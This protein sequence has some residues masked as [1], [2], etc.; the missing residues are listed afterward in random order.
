MTTNLATPPAAPPT[1]PAVRPIRVGFVL[2]AMQ[3]AGAEVL[4]TQTIRHL[5]G[6]IEPVVLCLDAVGPL[7]RR[8][9]A[10]GVPV[11]SLNR[12]PGR[13]WGV[14]RRLAGAVRAFDLELLHA[15]QYSPFFYAA[16]AKLLTWPRPKLVLTEHG[17]HFPDVVS[18]RRRL[19]NRWLLAGRADAVNA[20]C[21]FSARALR[22]LDGFTARPVEVIPNGVELE[23]YDAPA[24]RAALRARLGLAEGTVYVAHV[25]RHHPVK[26]QATLLHAF[27]EAARNR[28][29]AELLMAG[30]GPL[31]GKLEALAAT[32]KVAGRV[33]FLGVRR[34]VPDLLRAADVFTLPSVSEAASLTLLEAMASG[35]PAVVTDVGGNPELVRHER[36]GLLVPRGDAAA[37]AAALGRLID[38]TDE[39]RR[40]GE[41]GRR[42]ARARFRLGDTL[43]AYGR[44]Y[45]RL[46]RGRGE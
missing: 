33:Q 25:A 1:T 16:L 41:A 35:L 39:R 9:L 42:R 28:P 7:G 40:L 17:R 10:E 34:D 12:R 2:H 3:V 45:E 5:A 19:V 13:D 44:M 36:E 30:D 24:D 20:V 31:R 29:N 37:L 22:D 32:L 18:R 8:L 23:A 27:A 26:G 43:D 38:D 6:R 15:H 11:V 21:D 4:V 46:C 14:A